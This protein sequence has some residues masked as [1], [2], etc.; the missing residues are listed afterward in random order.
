MSGDPLLF[1]VHWIHVI[2]GVY[3]FGSVLYTNLVLFP[4]FG[5]LSP[6]SE[7]AARSA[8][9]SGRGGTITK[10]VSFATIGTGILR[11]LLSEVHERITSSYGLTY[12]GALAIGI[13]MLAYLH[14]AL[15]QSPGR[16][17]AYVASFP[18]IFTFM[19]ALRFGGF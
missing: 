7:A 9:R 3:W 15:R 10:V 14:D 17:R 12:L 1:A 13:L 8:L 18:V 4:V 5:R 2:L 6:D 19:V 11:G 16:D